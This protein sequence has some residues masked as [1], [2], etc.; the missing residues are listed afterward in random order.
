[1]ATIYL[2]TAFQKESREKNAFFFTNFGLTRQTRNAY[3]D[4]VLKPG[5]KAEATVDKALKDQTKENSKLYGKHFRLSNTIAALKAQQQK[6]AA[7]PSFLG[8]LRER[9]LLRSC[10]SLVKSEE[11]LLNQ[12]WENAA[13]LDSALFHDRAA[14]L[15]TLQAIEAGY[16]CVL[17]VAPKHPVAQRWLAE[18]GNN[19]QGVN[20]RIEVLRRRWAKLPDFDLVQGQ[21]APEL[22]G[23]EL[24]KPE[25]V[26]SPEELAEYE[27]MSEPKSPRSDELATGHENEMEAAA[28]RE[29][30]VLFD[31][32]GASTLASAAIS[33]RPFD[34][35]K[36][37]VA[38]KRDGR[39]RVADPAA[40]REK[41]RVAEKGAAQ[42]KTDE[43]PSKH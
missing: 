2:E 1:M 38:I 10:N 43:T 35:A 42:R 27:R 14:Q 16:G 3:H 13:K 17:D 31:E 19:I 25:L 36:N 24:Y 39:A 22:F 20:M 5:S 28:L 8:R 30:T 6:N 23:S 37:G 15:H 4:V 29:D 21:P 18:N 40:N 12:C 33:R 34:F 41:N 11:K 7:A 32:H 26:L 9:R